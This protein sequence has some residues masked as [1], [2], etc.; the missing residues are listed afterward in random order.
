VLLD[1]HDGKSSQHKAAHPA[2][3]SAARH[4]ERLEGTSRRTADTR[5]SDI[6]WDF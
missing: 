2:S 4:R 5:M 1:P 6:S 3:D